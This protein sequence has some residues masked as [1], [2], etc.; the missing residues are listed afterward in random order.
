MVPSKAAVIVP[1]WNRRDEVLACVESLLAMDYPDYSVIV[2]DNGSVDGTEK[3]LRARFGDSIVVLRNE[4]NLGYAGGNNCGIRYAMDNGA[5]YVCLVNNDAE[6]A[7]GYLTGL[8]A[9]SSGDERIGAVGCRNLELENPS[10]LWGAYGTITYGPFVV[11][12]EGQGVPDDSS[13]SGA[14][15]VD[16]IIGNGSL[17]RCSAIERAG[18]LDEDFFAYHD[19]VDWCVRF[20]TAGYRISYTGSVS[21]LHR[22]G[23]SSDI[24]KEHFFPL[25]YFLGRNGVLF[26]RKH[27]SWANTVRF[28]FWCSAAMAGRGLRALAT[29]LIPWLPQYDA[30]GHRYWDWEVSY[31]RG[32]IDG[33]LGRNTG[34]AVLQRG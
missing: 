5:E 4:I 24:R 9:A 12:M 19:D 2:V 1:T 32:I 21:I 31:W 22:G 14:R 3:A 16:W 30:R 23:G 13:W 11:R 6:V 20:R 10:R 15:D 25:P 18:L 26:V 8:V 28:A 7:E 33:L 17:W 29:R 27:A 34:V